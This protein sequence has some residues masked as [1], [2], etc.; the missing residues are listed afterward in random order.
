KPAL[1]QCLSCGGEREKLGVDGV[2]S[3]Q[4]RVAA[5]VTP[6]NPINTCAA[7]HEELKFDILVDA[8]NGPDV[9]ILTRFI[10]IAMLGKCRAEIISAIEAAPPHGKQ[11]F[12]A[13]NASRCNNSVHQRAPV[14]E[15]NEVDR[16][17]GCLKTSA[18]IDLATERV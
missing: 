5:P 17:F 11:R 10:P 3:P 8:I 16:N 18:F 12:P 13:L 4:S 15:I 7:D 6:I 9:P 2:P 1:Q 14:I